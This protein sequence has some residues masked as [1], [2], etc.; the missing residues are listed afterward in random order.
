MF[1]IRK[2]A[3]TMGGTKSCSP[4]PERQRNLDLQCYYELI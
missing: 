3:H 1:G 4:L 2:I